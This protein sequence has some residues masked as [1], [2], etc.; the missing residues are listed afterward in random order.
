[1]GATDKIGQSSAPSHPPEPVVRWNRTEKDYPLDRPVISYFE[2]QVR[3][4]PQRLAVQFEGAEFTY[5]ELNRRA[6]RVARE[7]IA[8]GVQPDDFVGVCMERSVELVVALLGV[9]K[10]GAA[11]V[12]F[13]PEYPRARLVHMFADSRARLVLTQQAVKSVAPQGSMTPLFLDDPALTTPGPEDELS[14]EFRGR[15]DTAVYMIYTSGS[16]GKPKGVPNLHRGLANRLLWMQETYQLGPDD[17][18]LQKT[19]L[20]WA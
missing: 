12:P 14:P 18:V 11:Y 5:A 3:D 8:R 2:Q 1:M 20:A 10:A 15:P 9:V 7:L 19:P 4:A 6:N 16:T 17:R 13:D